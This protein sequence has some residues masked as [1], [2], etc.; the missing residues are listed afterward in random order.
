[1]SAGQGSRYG[2]LNFALHQLGR[3]Y[4]LDHSETAGPDQTAGKCGSRRSNATLAGLVKHMEGTEWKRQMK[5]D[6]RVR[7]HVPI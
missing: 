3:T 4:D 5:W 6:S 2:L 1:M 7:I